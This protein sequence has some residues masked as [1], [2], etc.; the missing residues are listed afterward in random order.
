M[1]TIK[2]SID[3]SWALLTPIPEVHL[4][5]A[6]DILRTKSEVSFGSNSFEVFRQLD[7]HAKTHPV[8]VMIYCSQEGEVKH[9]FD[10]SWFG[11]YVRKEE[12]KNSRPSDPSLR[13]TTAIDEKWATFWHL[14]ALCELPTGK[15]VPI[16]K[17]S[18]LSGGKWK[19]APVRGPTIVELPEALSYETLISQ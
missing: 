9:N 5:S 3:H 4:R 17:I 11:W 8:P 2:A 18:K 12:P 15:R 14:T 16:A 6:L 13:P 7:F 19:P 10:V 1:A